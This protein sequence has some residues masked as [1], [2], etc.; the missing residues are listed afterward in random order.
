MSTI[1]LTL[2]SLAIT[3]FTG[4]SAAQAQEDSPNQSKSLDRQSQVG[5]PHEGSET[6]QGDRYEARRA[7][8]NDDRSENAHHDYLAQ[9]PTIEEAI[10][11]KLKKGNEAEIELAKLAM[12]KTDNEDVRQLCQTLIQDHE[13]CIEKIQQTSAKRNAQSHIE[14]SMNQSATVP[15]QLC[16]IAEVACENSLMMTKEMLSNYEGQDFNMA[17][18]GQQCVAHT[19]MLAELKAIENTGPQELQ[20][21]AQDAIGKV[22]KHLERCKEIAKQLEDDRD[23]PS[24]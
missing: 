19:T 23:K 7:S 20:P 8:T 11:Q 24:S 22:K 16:R 10:L 4:F 17:F 21:I 13:A 3:A 5:H 2:A 9:G 15:K 18:L 12:N 1:R 6:N 14:A